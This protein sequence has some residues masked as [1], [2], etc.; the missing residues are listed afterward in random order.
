MSDDLNQRIRARFDHQQS[1]RVLREKY[2]ARML[3]AHAGG[4]WCA[5]PALLTT[6]ACCPD[7]M[8][9]LQDEYQNP[10]QVRRDELRDLALSR[11]QENMNAWL[12]EW[13]QQSRAR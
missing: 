6:L 13:Q 10:V 12:V 9:V 2:Q 5:G 11:W 1:R 3:F 4:L 8:I 7:G